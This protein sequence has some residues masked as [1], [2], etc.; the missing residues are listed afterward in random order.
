MT[1]INSD[2]RLSDDSEFVTDIVSDCS[3]S[4]LTCPE[5]AGSTDEAED[6]SL[7]AMDEIE[8]SD[9]ELTDE[10]VD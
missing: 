8:L 4:E 2:A 3:C 6:D 5:V 7:V 10:L 1:T 9:D